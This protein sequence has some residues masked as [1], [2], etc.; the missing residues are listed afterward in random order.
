MT[1]APPRNELL[2]VTGGNLRV[3]KFLEDLASGGG[4]S[5]GSVDWADVT[6][7]PLT[8]PPAVHSHAITDVTGL[9]AALAAVPDPLLVWFI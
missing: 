7:K 3:T 8:F 6:G 5:V 2:A 1:K 4:G 9:Q